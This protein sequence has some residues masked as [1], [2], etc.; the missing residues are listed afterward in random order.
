VSC[1]SSQRRTNDGG[2]SRHS[3]E[4]VATPTAMQAEDASVALGASTT[5]SRAL[6][7]KGGDRSRTSMGRS[8]SA[9]EQTIANG[10]ERW[11]AAVSQTTLQIMQRRLQSNTALY[12]HAA[13]AVGSSAV[14]CNV[15]SQQQRQQRKSQGS[16]SR[17]QVTSPAPSATALPGDV[18][19]GSESEQ[20]LQLHSMIGTGSF[21][22]VYLGSWR[23]KRVAV[24]VMHLQS[25]ALLDADHSGRH[26]QDVKQGQQQERLQRQ[27]AQNSPPHMAIMEAVVSS[28][29][30]HPN[31]S[32]GPCA[33]CVLLSACMHCPSFSQAVPSCALSVYC[34]RVCCVVPDVLL[35]CYCCWCVCLCRW[36]R[37]THTCSAR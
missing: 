2:A 27:R 23:G 32:A 15:G 24:K 11:N 9:V 26:S 29:M 12:G 37:C 33:S 5:D 6:D 1:S 4:S 35:L 16:P 18:M 19:G 20:G 25:N 13:S 31:V 17:S 30:S 22:S 14:S 34:C 7:G 21:G 10:L 8:P 36:F 3:S 28:T